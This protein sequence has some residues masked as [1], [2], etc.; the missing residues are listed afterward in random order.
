MAYKNVPNQPGIKYDSVNRTYLVYRIV[1]GEEQY[2]GQIKSLAEAIRVRDAFVKALPAETMA[3]FNVRTKKGKGKIDTKELQKASRWFYK[4]GEVDSPNYFD[5]KDKQLRKV[6]SNVARGKPPGKFSKINQFTPLKPH[7]QRKILKEF[8]EANF[9]LWKKGFDSNIDTQ[10]SSAVDSFIARGYKPAFWNVKN[11]PKKTQELIIEA[12]GKEAKAAGT[13]IRFGPGR[14]LGITPTENLR[15]N[16][17]IDGFVRNMGKTHPYAFSTNRP[18]NWIITQMHRAA[19]ANNPDYKMLRNEAGKIIGASEKGV[20]YYHVN[21]MKGNLI[22]SHPEAEQISK[23][24]SIAKKAR[25]DIPTSLLKIFPKGFDQKL[26]SSNRAYTDLLRWLDNTQGRRVVA[27]AINVHHAGE[28]AVAG[29]PALARDLQLLTAQDNLSAASIRMAIETDLDKGRNPFTSEGSR[30]PELKEKGIRL[31]VRGVEYG[32]GPETPEAGLKRIEKASLSKLQA[33]LKIDP[34]LGGFANFL[35]Q[36]VIGSK[37]NAG[38]MCK[39]PSIMQNVA[40]GG[41]IGFAAGS[42]CAAEMEIA[43]NKNPIKVTQEIAELPGN[44]TINTFKNTAKGLLGTLGKFGTKA[45]P[46]AALAVA[47]AAIEPLVKQFVADDPNTYLTN[48]NQMKGMLLATIEG[49]TPK[50]DEEILKWQLPTLGAATA[51]GAIPGAKTAYLERRGIGPTGPLPEGVGKT[52][53]ALGIK[54]V[55]GKALG[56]TFSPLA[57]AATLPLTVAAQRKGG[58]EW[59]DIATDPMNWMA[60]AFASSGYEAASKGITNPMLLKALRLGIS[61]SVLRTIASR[62]GIP[63]L[64][65]SGGLWGYDKW[66]NRSIN[67]PED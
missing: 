44:K 20:D 57:V 34:K 10:R 7:Q 1:K 18:E 2:Q 25:A 14:K 51:A 61:P 40:G 46:L 30:I 32:V 35:K 48:E 17:I 21:S 41:R 65:I 59:G 12:F 3:E 56:A 36:A 9:D 47:G 8:P 22:S 28:G 4:R 52:R 26:L 66:K 29:S 54:G 43:I 53:A 23:F 63:G 27:N 15:L 62:F 16:K 49:E 13:P 37:T 19:D 24:V 55:L 58:T 45:A 38:G 39:I 6:R 60:P 67:D 11:L 33:Q 64:L 42:N 50:V 5:L 31:N